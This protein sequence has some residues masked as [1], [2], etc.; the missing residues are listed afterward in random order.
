M[1]VGEIVRE[2]GRWSCGLVEVTGGEPLAQPEVI[3]LMQKLLE[4]GYEVLLETG[5][6]LPIGQVPPGVR[7]IVDVKCPGSGESEKN[8]WTN[9]DLLGEGDE[10]KFVLA[11]RDDYLWALER[12]S[13]HRIE[14][15][16]PVHFSPVHGKLDPGTLARWVL[17]DGIQV[18][19]QLQIHKVLW[20]GEERGV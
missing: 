16:C 3:A 14:T 2:V 4:R 13:E 8:L 1:E 20:P 17:D 9:L 11:D 18:R 6:S 10:V 12:L 15:R 5:G 7:R 19:V